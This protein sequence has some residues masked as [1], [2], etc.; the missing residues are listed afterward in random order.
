MRTPPAA[1]SI[2]SSN[3]AIASQTAA[4]EA[5]GRPSREVANSANTASNAG[6]AS[7]NQNIGVAAAEARSGARTE[8]RQQRRQRH[9]AAAAGGQQQAPTWRPC[10]RRHRTAG[11]RVDQRVGL[12]RL[13]PS[14]QGEPLQA[15]VDADL[16]R[17]FG[18]SGARRR[19]GDAQA[20]ELDVDDRQT[21]A[22]GQRG[23]QGQQVAPR[24]PPAGLRRRVDERGLRILVERQ[25]DRRR[26]PTRARRP[27]TSL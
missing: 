16:D 19:L 20:L 1:I 21:L 3:A 27:S 15:A 4:A 17:R 25:V 9:Q 6:K 23:E 10:V 8:Q 22:L 11:Q 12:H 13:A 18:H 2:V 26:A 14:L 7:F 24:L 5:P